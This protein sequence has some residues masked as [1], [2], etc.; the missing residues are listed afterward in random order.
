MK[1][2]FRPVRRMA[3][4][5]KNGRA[6]NRVSIRLLLPV[7]LLIP[8][9][10]IYM[11]DLRLRPAVAAAAT[12]VAKHA[13]SEAINHA[14]TDELAENENTV[15]LV[16]VKSHFGS[17]N[18]TIAKFNVQEMARLQ[19]ETAT[20]VD[21][22]L[23]QLSTQKISLPAS[24]VIGDA[25]FSLGNFKIPLKLSIVGTANSSVYADVQSA[26]VNQT[27]HILYLDVSADVNVI[28]P[29]ITKPVHL[30]TK[31]PVAYLV[32]SGPVPD[33]Y[34]HDSKIPTEQK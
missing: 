20:R 2:Q 30:A 4:Q 11:L 29:L 3:G 23:A 19:S 14:L 7:F 15:N 18:M 13:A 6:V 9:I 8:A 16:E 17:Q 12:A 31:T 25:I 1:Q 32:L 5:R 26:G 28:T 21:S 10:S 33:V 24:Q 22:E 27:V 34:Y